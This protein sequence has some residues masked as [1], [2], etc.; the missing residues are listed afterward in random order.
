MDR[1]ELAPE[2]ERGLALVAEGLA[3]LAD[4]DV[5]PVDADGANEL[6]RRIEAIGSQVDHLQARIVGAIEDA[7][8]SLRTAIARRRRWSST[9][10]IWPLPRH[11]VVPVASGRCEPCRPSLR[12]TPPG[13]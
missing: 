2:V 10:L 7:R 4:A 9:S 8:T 12:P 13:A 5:R 6:I 3:V 11:P 1:R